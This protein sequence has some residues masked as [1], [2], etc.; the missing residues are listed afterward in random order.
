MPR[1][2]DVYRLFARG[3]PIALCK[4]SLASG[5]KS[6]TELAIQVIAAEGPGYRRLGSSEGRSPPAYRSAQE[7]ELARPDRAR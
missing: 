3:E 4:E 6:T 5:P 7:A 2:V 1:Y